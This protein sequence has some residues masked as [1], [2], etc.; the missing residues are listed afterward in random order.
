MAKGNRFEDLLNQQNEENKEYLGT[1]RSPL[2][3]ETAPVEVEEE[4]PVKKRTPR[5]PEKIVEPEPSL[6]FVKREKEI[7]SVRKFILITPA[8][9]AWL[10]KTAKAADISVNE[11]FNQM[12][13]KERGVL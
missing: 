6:G 12:I 1:G 5:S 3:L 11:L 9:D 13:E 4:L 10:R 7:R 8:N 2:Q